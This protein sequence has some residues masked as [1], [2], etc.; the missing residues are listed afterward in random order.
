MTITVAYNSFGKDSLI[1]VFYYRSSNHI[2]NN[3][4]NPITYVCSINGGG[5]TRYLMGGSKQFIL[6]QRVMTH[7]YRSGAEIYCKKCGLQLHVGDQ[8]TTNKNSYCSK[9]SN[10]YHT[11]CWEGTRI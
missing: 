9:H 4:Y 7:R 6:T 10:I 1:T 5:E 8:V 2:V 3:H 11:A